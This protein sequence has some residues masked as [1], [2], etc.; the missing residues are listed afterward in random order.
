MKKITLSIFS[1]LLAITA[2]AQNFSWVGGFNTSNSFGNYGIQ[3][4]PSSSNQPEARTGAANWIDASNNLWLFGGN[5]QTGRK[6]DLWKFNTT[7]NQWVWLKGP[8][9]IDDQGSSGTKGVTAASN[10][11]SARDGGITWMDTSGNLWLFGGFGF[12]L[13]GTGLGALNDLWKYNTNTNEWTWISGDNT[14]DI[15]GIYGTIGV[16]NS[17]NKMGGRYLAASWV[18]NLNNLWLFG[19]IGF[20][21]V[22]TSA[23]NQN[24]LWKYN[25]TTNEWTW[26][27][28]SNFQSQFGTYG[29]KSIASVSNTPGARNSV[30]SWK[31]GNGNLYLFGGNGFA[32]TSAGSL[33]DFWRFNSITTQWTWMKGDSIADKKAVY[34]VINVTNPLSI[35][36]SRSL[37]GSW[38]ESNGNFF[39]FG[40]Q[41]KTANTVGNVSLN[42]IWKLDLSTNNWT[43]VG[44]DS[45][46]NKLGNYGT[47]NV[48]AATNQM[49]SRSRHNCWV[50]S[51]GKVWVFGGQGYSSTGG[52]GNLNDLWSNS[53]IPTSL[54]E[55]SNIPNFT[56]Y[57]N[58]T[59][60]IL[61]IEVKEQTQIS[62]LNILGEVV[63]TETI[64]G[65]SKL[66][67]S[68]LTTGVYFIQ[69]SKSGKAI[70]F[71]KE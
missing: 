44:G 35:P 11:P 13:S 36:G 6:N 15:N 66:D 2:T 23:N 69:D 17:A 10:N 39:L 37:A 27:S 62:I 12:P 22:N 34:G 58:P 32:N 8:N 60:S 38:V 5:T 33:N 47:L 63:K 21:S 53:S 28:G 4:V 67:V 42:D 9:T 54:N 61:N 68:D 48:P 18:D 43:W 56:L 70:K 14:K 71:I 49:G 29:T 30:A 55:I 16:S 64:N 7:T 19:G 3:G 57:P 1:F 25:V 45:I 26:V 59:T 52:F 65:A 31:D 51:T 41:G 24:D 50:E 20:S 40:G 46:G